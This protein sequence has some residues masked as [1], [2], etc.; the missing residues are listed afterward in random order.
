MAL[1]FTAPASSPRRLHRQRVRRAWG[2]FFFTLPLL[3]GG[4]AALLL[5]FLPPWGA[6]E[7]NSI[8]AVP[9]AAPEAAPRPRQAPANAPQVS[10][11]PISPPEA[12]LTLPALPPNTTAAALPPLAESDIS[13]EPDNA[14]ADGDSLTLTPEPSEATESNETPPHS[15]PP[16]LAR[17][18][19]KQTAANKPAPTEHSGSAANSAPS[20]RTPPAYLSN[21]QPPYPA[22]MRSRRLT[23]TVGVR[24]HISAT[25]EA[26][27]VEITSPS[28]HREFDTATRTWI[29]RHWRFRPATENGNAVPAAVRTDVRYS[30]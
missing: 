29:L 8:T 25:G 10:L 5:Q 2:A 11:P 22:A 23:G 26:T 1:R 30:M 24:I 15:A 14:A 19:P 12:P 17:P 6:L 13:W 27:E 3:L 28:G 20:K 9:Y 4:A 21:P 7:H 18:T 16:A